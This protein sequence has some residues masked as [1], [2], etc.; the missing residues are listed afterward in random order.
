MK[1]RT[2]RLGIRIVLR[3]TNNKP[4]QLRRVPKTDNLAYM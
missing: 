4:L 2:K 3:P 1:G